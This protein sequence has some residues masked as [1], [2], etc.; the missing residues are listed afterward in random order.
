MTSI[1]KGK[2]MRNDLCRFVMLAGL[3]SLLI[4]ASACSS[5]DSQPSLDGYWNLVSNHDNAAG[6]TT[7]VPSGTAVEEIVVADCDLDCVEYSRTHWPFLRDRR[8]NELYMSDGTTKGCGLN[9]YTV[10]GNAI[11]YSDGGQNLME[12]TDKTLRLTTLK[13][14]TPIGYSDFVRLATFS[15]EG[16]DTCKSS[17]SGADAG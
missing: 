7:P 10:L 17:N 11:T 14:G 3:G 5:P 12:V 1:G 16:Y 6:T 9:T 2:L 4:L 15:A 13:N 8:V